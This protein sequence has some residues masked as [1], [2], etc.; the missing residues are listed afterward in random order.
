MK[1]TRWLGPVA[2]LLSMAVAAC[3]PDMERIAAAA[4]ATKRPRN[5][6]VVMKE[7]LLVRRH[8]RPHEYAPRTGQYEVLCNF[9]VAKSRFQVGRMARTLLQRSICGGGC[10]NRFFT[11]PLAG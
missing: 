10:V 6:L 7:F 1:P 4:V 11:M 9:N 8:G 5:E 3:A 2:I